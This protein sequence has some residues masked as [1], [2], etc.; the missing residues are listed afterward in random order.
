MDIHTVLP[1]SLLRERLL[2]LSELYARADRAVDIFQAASGLGC[3]FGCGS[4]CESFIPDILPAEAELVALD[5]VARDRDQAFRLAASGLEPRQSASG[6]PG[7]PLYRDDTPYHCSVYASRPLICRL[8]A[9]SAVR[10]KHGTA[11]YSL[12]RLMPAGPGTPRSAA[13]GDLAAAF[14]AEPPVMGD[15]GAE[16]AALD[17][18][19]AGGRLPLHEALPPAIMR[20]LFMAGLGTNPENDGP[21]LSPPLPQAS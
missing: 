4:C 9:F 12:C 14:G 1:P 7:C 6:T 3:P 10:D 18:G 16:L 11:A 13:N 5:L 8:F 20:V 15:Y 17:P 21:N 2:A 19:S